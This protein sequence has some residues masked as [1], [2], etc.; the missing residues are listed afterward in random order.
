[1]LLFMLV[2]YLFEFCK[3][4]DL[5]DISGKVGIFCSMKFYIELFLVIATYC[6]E[7]KDN[8]HDIVDEYF[9]GTKTG[10]YH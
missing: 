4:K 1:M 8:C 6:N 7:A 10:R 2:F 5:V 9:I 3:S